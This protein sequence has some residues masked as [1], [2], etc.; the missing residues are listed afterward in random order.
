MKK[1]KTISSLSSLTAALA[2]LAA[3]AATAFGQGTTVDTA[4][5]P[6]LV[7][8]AATV[9]ITPPVGVA[10]L[11]GV[12]K[13]VA[14]NRRDTLV[15]PIGQRTSVS[16]IGQERS[17]ITPAFTYSMGSVSLRI[18]AHVYGSRAEISLYS[19]N[20]RRVLRGKAD[21]AGGGFN[22]SRENVASGVYLLTVK[23][24]DGNVFTS[25]LTHSGGRL[26]VSAAFSGENASLT[27]LNRS[28]NSAAAADGEW[29]ITASASGYQT[30]SYSII[31]VGG[32]NPLQNIT[33]VRPGE[34]GYQTSFC[35]GMAISGVI[36]NST[37]IPAEGACVFIRNFD[38]IQPSL[39][40]TIA[41]NGLENTCGDEW[42]DHPGGPCQF[43]T[44]PA[45]I[46]GGYY[47]YV[48]SGSVNS[49]RPEG[50]AHPNG[51]QNVIA[52]VRSE[53]CGTPD[54]TPQLVMRTA[55]N[56][57]LMSD[58]PDP[59]VVRVGNAYYMVTTTMHFMPTTPI[60]KSY[61]LI[62]WR[63]IS[64]CADI[65]VDRP[66]FR[67]ENGQ[68]YS[69]GQWASSIRYFKGRFWVM[70]FGRGLD[71]FI[72][73]TEDPENGPWVRS[74]LPNYYHDPSLF[75][76]EDTD[77]IWVMHGYENID[78]TE[79]EM[80]GTNSIRRR[81][82]GVNRRILND[83]GE[84]VQVYKLNGY[85]YAFTIS[86]GPGRRAVYVNRSRN[87][88][89]PFEQRTVLNRVLDGGKG[90]GV[91]QGGIIQTPEGDWYGIF[92]Q[93]RDA[94][95]RVPVLVPMRW[96]ADH[97]P[98]FGDANGNIPTTFQIRQVVNHEQN[99]F[100]SD[101]FDSNRLKLAW[102][103]NHNPDNANW[104][105]TARPG[106]LRLTARVA[107]NVYYARN[108][109]TQRTIE[110]SCTATTAIEV[111]NMRDGDIAGLL[112][113]LPRSGFVG[114]EQ[115]GNQRFVVMYTGD[116]ETQTPNR[117]GLNAEI[118]REARVAF[119]GNRIYL[120]AICQFRRQGVTTETARFSYSLDGQTWT[121]IGTTLNMQWT[122]THFTGARFGLFNYATRTAGGYVDFDYFRV[123]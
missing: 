19:V 87:I 83:V 35:G 91:A 95:G 102:Q 97:W 80:V 105:L 14:A 107:R 119:T 56:P 9:S 85:Y 33:L 74:T 1:T 108:T 81:P 55:T 42:G 50:A 32:M 27:A 43:N 6:V 62:N 96:S 7:N 76:D 71:S 51:W 78:L 70:I 47:V 113:L 77:R 10:G 60:M 65:I 109:L 61:D 39:N 117:R 114:V 100:V 99:Y 93:D 13:N 98:V 40:S 118:T 18:P 52:G 24:V 5:V 21:A 88:D 3:F 53:L 37:A 104:S 123:R 106:F 44:K 64:Y 116:N 92:F 68:E 112:V 59:S 63:I 122:M 67:F 79:M 17:D 23:G 111:A 75:Y 69:N 45:P 58:F 94:I 38:R 110:P 73:S 49:F 12:T 28:A 25:R 29:T 82:N 41:I 2:T 57:L 26:N 30:A 36:H 84:G 86:W 31:P 16:H 22:M 90:G 20:G 8:V 115:E 121:N 48:K 72:F 15:F 120:R 11:S 103:W 101:E 54:T 46:D 89:G 4:R 34:C 66:S